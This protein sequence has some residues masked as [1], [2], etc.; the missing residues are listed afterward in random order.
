[1]LK[2]QLD[3]GLSRLKE[4]EFPNL[5][6]AYEPVWAIGTGVVATPEQ[7]RDAH[8]FVRTRLKAMCGDRAKAIPILY[9]G[10]VTSENCLTLMSQPNI[11][12]A[13][14]GG[15]S[16]KVDSLLKLHAACAAAGKQEP[17]NPNREWK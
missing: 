11:D 7:A 2:R 12:G 5:V 9:G 17:Q 14:V 3:I 6:V 1:M 16:L 4:D 15:A 10:S 8:M 13:L